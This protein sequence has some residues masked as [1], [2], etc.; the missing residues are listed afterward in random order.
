MSAPVAG[1]HPHASGLLVPE[2]HA[3]ERIV[4]TYEDWKKLDRALAMLDRLALRMQFRCER[5]RCSPIVKVNTP[6]GGTVLR[7]DHADRVFT[8]AF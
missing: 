7:C 5:P 4:C 6:D 2:A 1:F 8:K 3:R